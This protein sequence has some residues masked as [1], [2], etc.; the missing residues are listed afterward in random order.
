M[1]AEAIYK[2]VQQCTTIRG[3]HLDD[4]KFQSGLKIGILKCQAVH[5]TDFYHFPRQICKIEAILEKGVQFHLI[6]TPLMT[7]EL[8]IFRKSHTIVSFDRE[9][10]SYLHSRPQ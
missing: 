2:S 3:C 6:D 9:Y 4:W 8:Y 7:V 5:I 10:D 1:W